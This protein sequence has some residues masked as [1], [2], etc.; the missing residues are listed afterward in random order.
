MQKSR[1]LEQ[2]T[3]IK[4]YRERIWALPSERHG[5]ISPRRSPFGTPSFPYLHNQ[6][7]GLP[8]HQNIVSRSSACQKHRPNN[9]LKTTYTFPLLISTA[10]VPD[11]TLPS[12]RPTRPV[13]SWCVPRCLLDRAAVLDLGFRISTVG[14]C[15]QARV[16]MENTREQE[17]ARNARAAQRDEHASTRGRRTRKSEQ[18]GDASMQTNANGRKHEGGGSTSVQSDAGARRNTSRA[19]S[20]TWADGTR[21][22][23]YAGR[24][25]AGSTM[26]QA[27]T[28]N[29]GG[30]EYE[31]ASGTMVRG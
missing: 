1:R 4:C 13:S 18:Y 6:P 11:A 27:R 8:V 9:Y 10:R 3:T 21:T 23:P 28:T 22:Q 2:S 17:Q 30:R 24:R 31:S 25:S 15:R 26:V 5:S 7:T 12:R 14:A 20:Q 19:R 16:G 29:A